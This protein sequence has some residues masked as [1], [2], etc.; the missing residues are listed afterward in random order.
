MPL[1]KATKSAWEGIIEDEVLLPQPK[2]AKLPA[3]TDAATKLVCLCIEQAPQKID[4][5]SKPLTDKP[6]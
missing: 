3:I 5:P 2:R 1:L 6:P 4:K